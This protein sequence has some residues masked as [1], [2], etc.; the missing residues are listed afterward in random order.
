MTHIDTKWL[1]WPSEQLRF[2]IQTRGGVPT[3]FVF[4]L[5]YNHEPSPERESDWRQVVRFDHDED[6]E[7]DVREEGIHMDVHYQSGEKAAQVRGFP[8][9]DIREVPPYCER[10]IE[11]N[12][13]FYVDN[14][15]NDWE[16]LSRL[17]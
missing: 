12:Y 5:E 17:V 14:Y 13:Q 10:H 2:E 16:D 6:G 1:S 3:R 15:K 4:Q 7:H 8:D 9:L 11:E